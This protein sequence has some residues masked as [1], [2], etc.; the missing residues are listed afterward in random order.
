MTAEALENLAAL[1]RDAAEFIRP[2]Q[3]A[4]AS[5]FEAAA[6]AAE[7]LAIQERA[8]EAASRRQLTGAGL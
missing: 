5:R 1:N 6:S 7:F 4:L 2:E 8:G 3:P